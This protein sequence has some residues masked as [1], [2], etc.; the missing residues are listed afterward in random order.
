MRLIQSI[1]LAIFL[2]APS[3]IASPLSFTSD[4]NVLVFGSM[5]ASNSSIGGSVAVGGSASF[6]NLSIASGNGSASGSVPASGP[7]VLN[8]IVGGSLQWGNGSLAKGSGVYQGTALL[9]N[10]GTP[11]G[12]INFGVSP[13]DFLSLASEAQAASAGYAAL[14]SNGDAVYQWGG[15]TLTGTDAELNVFEIA[16]S[17][18]SSLNSLK[19]VVP[20]GAAVLINITGS[21]ASLSNFGITLNGQGFNHNQNADAW[22]QVLWNFAAAGTFTTNG[23]HLGG[24]L[25]APTAS[26]SLSN[27]K[28]SGQV[29]AG[30]LTSTAAINN[31]AY[32]GFPLPAGSSGPET[33]AD[34]AP[35]PEPGTYLLTACG[36]ML[37]LGGKFRRNRARQSA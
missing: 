18:L 4:H 8:L 9:A 28:V 37:L 1:L 27:G 24:T 7:D 30:S 35:V 36:L 23:I 2:M 13:V 17:S 21:S 20:E 33:P 31:F 26:V 25:L 29:V 11:G 34:V 5:S 12:S 14:D 3:A 6:A 22:S 16:G 32:A 19:I 10:L 15:L